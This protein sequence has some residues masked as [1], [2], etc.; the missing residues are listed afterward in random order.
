MQTHCNLL[1]Q[2]QLALTQVRDGTAA[3]HHARTLVNSIDNQML[4]RITTLVKTN[5]LHESLKQKL[6]DNEEILKY[7][8]ISKPLNE[9]LDQH[10]D[11]YETRRKVSELEIELTN[12]VLSILKNDPIY[13]EL[14]QDSLSRDW[15]L[16]ES[17][18]K[19]NGFKMDL[20]ARE[21]AYEE[22]RE[23]QLK[24]FCDKLQKGGSDCNRRYSAAT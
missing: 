20:V 3:T 1:H 22:S 2:V 24:E 15:N 16:K 10:P 9:S 14:K 23:G 7:L 21:A 12:L 18:D 8:R 4:T 19:L 6:I 5:P 11:F 13:Q 17:I